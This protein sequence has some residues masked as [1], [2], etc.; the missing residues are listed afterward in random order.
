[1]QITGAA[2]ILARAGASQIYRRQDR[3][4]AN[5]LLTLGVNLVRL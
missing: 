1:M 2:A 4:L 3:N 5:I